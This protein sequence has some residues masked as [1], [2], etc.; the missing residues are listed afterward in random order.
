MKALY[1][2]TGQYID[3]RYIGKLNGVKH[4]L[5]KRSSQIFS[6]KSLKFETNENKGT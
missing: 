3:V 2:K 4:F 5:D 1:L 6:E